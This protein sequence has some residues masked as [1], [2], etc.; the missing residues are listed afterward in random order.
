MDDVSDKRPLAD[1]I[2]ALD[3]TLLSS[4]ESL[5]TD[6]D[7]RSLLALHAATAETLGVFK[8]LEIGSYLGG[9]LQA[10][11]QDPR[12]TSIISID[13]R[14]DLTPH[15]EGETYSYPDNT[16]AQMLE[17]LSKLPDGDMAKLATYDCGTDSLTVQELH[18]RPDYC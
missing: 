12:C 14:P 4:V 18:V 2:S 1:R 15:L 13:P 5:M 16:K 17:L 6:W 10:L 9:S 8:Y 7:R 11:M 3:P